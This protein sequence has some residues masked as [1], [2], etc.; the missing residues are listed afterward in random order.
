MD[1]LYK[2]TWRSSAG[3][4]KYFAHR[5]VIIDEIE[6]MMRVRNWTSK[7]AVDYLDEI[8][9]SN[10]LLKL[11]EALKRRKK[12]GVAAGHLADLGSEILTQL[13]DERHAIANEE[14]EDD[15]GSGEE[16]AEED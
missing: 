7:T 2:H 3:E 1:S 5:K 10:S 15:E 4:R 12:A 9:G 8:K 11:S 13:D 6:A 14:D 16:E